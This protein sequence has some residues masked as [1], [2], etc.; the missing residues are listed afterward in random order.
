MVRR[1]IVGSVRNRCV[2]LPILVVRVR[3]SAGD[4]ISAGT[5]GTSL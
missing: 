4:T 2:R 5:T 1:D 3:R